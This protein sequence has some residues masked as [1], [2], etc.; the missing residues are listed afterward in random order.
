M[1]CVPFAVLVLFRS[2]Y[3]ISSVRCRRL[4][5]GPACTPSGWMAQLLDIAMLI[6]VHSQEYFTLNIR[7]DETRYQYLL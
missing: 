7:Y 3:C 2:Q 1:H 5:G 6:R 4:I